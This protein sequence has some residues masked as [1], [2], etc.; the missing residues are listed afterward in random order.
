L[1]FGVDVGQLGRPGVGVHRLEQGFGAGVLEMG[2]EHDQPGL[3][4]AGR[5]R[6]R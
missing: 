4:V 5:V 1:D 6:G 2:A 3:M